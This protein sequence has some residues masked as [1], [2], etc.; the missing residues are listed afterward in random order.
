VLRFV[1]GDCFCQASVLTGATT[2]F[3][4]VAL[5]PVTVYEICGT[6]LA[7]ILKARPAIAV[8]LGQLMARRIKAGETLFSDLDEADKHAGHLATRL[9]D[10]IKLLFGLS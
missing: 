8:E 5:T 10:R 3:K 7:P 2:T 6:D 4:I 9:A 1:P